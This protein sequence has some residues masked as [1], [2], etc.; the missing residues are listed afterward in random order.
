MDAIVVA[1]AGQKPDPRFDVAGTWRMP[2]GHGRQLM[3]G[4]LR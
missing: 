2:D 4:G 1:E 3:A